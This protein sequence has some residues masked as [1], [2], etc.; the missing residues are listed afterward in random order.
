M[1]D[2]ELVAQIAQEA[3]ELADVPKI[4]VR[5]FYQ[6][7]VARCHFCGAVVQKATLEP[8]DKNRKGVQRLACE[9]CRG[10]SR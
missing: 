7:A 8:W 3:K 2:E 10:I 4:P 1:P 9:V 6:G 5:Q